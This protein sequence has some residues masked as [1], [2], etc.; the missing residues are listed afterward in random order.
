MSEKIAFDVA[1]DAV[2]QLDVESQKELAD[3]LK[4]IARVYLSI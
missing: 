1:L 3:I 4:L 2:E